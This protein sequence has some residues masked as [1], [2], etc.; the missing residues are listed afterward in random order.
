[1]V[2]FICGYGDYVGRYAYIGQKFAEQ[3]YD[4][5]GIDKRGQGHSEGRKG[6]YES[7]RSLL[8]D[9]LEFTHQ[10]DKEIL[11]NEKV[12]HFIMG[13]SLGCMLGLTMVVEEPTLFNGISMTVPCLKI[14]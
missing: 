3:G 4:F 11:Q 8:E 12:P 1:M 14:G 13:N 5:V 2:Q 7:T 9:Q 6:V 10:H